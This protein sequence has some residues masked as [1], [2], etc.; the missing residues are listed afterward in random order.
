MDT[1]TKQP[2][3]ISR[4][5][6]LDA[7]KAGGQAFRDGKDLADCPYAGA[8]TAAAFLAHHWRKGY[9]LAADDA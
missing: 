5:A 7:N 1:E 6:A 2:T 3:K 9:R 8:D 4:R